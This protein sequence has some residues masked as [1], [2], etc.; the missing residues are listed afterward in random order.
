MK[1]TLQSSV[2]D[3]GQTTDGLRSLLSVKGPPITRT[4]SQ[5]SPHQSGFVR[6]DRHIFSSLHMYSVKNKIPFAKD[7][8]PE[9][10]LLIPRLVQED[11]DNQGLRCINHAMKLLGP[12][13][14]RLVSQF[15]DRK[16]RRPRLVLSYM[17]D[18]FDLSASDLAH[19]IT[20]SR[21]GVPLFTVAFQRQSPLETKVMNALQQLLEFT[22]QHSEG[23]PN[24]ALRAVVERIK[25]W[26][27]VQ[28]CDT[29]FH[30]DGSR[31]LAY[32]DLGNL[33]LR[34][35]LRTN[36]VEL[37]DNSF[38]LPSTT[39]NWNRSARFSGEC[40]IAARLLHQ[41]QAIFSYKSD[42]SCSITPSFREF[43]HNRPSTD[44]FH[45]MVHWRV[46]QVRGS[47]LGISHVNEKVAADS[48]YTHRM[49][50]GEVLST[51]EELFR[52][53]RRSCA[54]NRSISRGT[55][56][57]V[58]RKAILADILCAQRR[59]RLTTGIAHEIIAEAI[60]HIGNNLQFDPWKA[61]MI[62]VVTSQHEVTPHHVMA[63]REKLTIIFPNEVLAQKPE[64]LL[65]K[66]SA[67]ETWV[68]VIQKY[69]ADYDKHCS[70]K[71]LRAVVQDLRE[72]RRQG[73][74][75]L[76]QKKVAT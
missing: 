44:F 9:L 18:R 2:P 13:E 63:K 5:Q 30:R 46:A 29:G 39:T 59:L 33:L 68:K 58:A 74:L 32:R 15:D 23:M 51:F 37:D 60:F 72:I 28:E 27:L 25:L 12:G 61:Q 57:P 76:R 73:N 22:D 67:L 21:I 42:G 35:A 4:E 41:A 62:P 50:L 6:S 54:L 52:L 71:G 43:R 49:S 17:R 38:I 40:R 66:L 69:L 16:T 8:L 14:L 26:E 24:A 55:F 56:H 31:G 47:I 53:T 45:E 64:R 10:S 36:G 19:T 1:F 70:T 34:I 7:G 65:L 11:P 20:G 75:F 48:S 3:I